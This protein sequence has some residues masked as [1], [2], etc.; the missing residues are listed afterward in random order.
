MAH[1]RVS[2]RRFGGPCPLD[3]LG[4]TMLDR[5]HGEIYFECDSCGDTLETPAREFQEA[6]VSLKVSKWKAR[7]VCGEWL[8]ECPDCQRPKPQ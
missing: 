5:I 6:L 1:H 2:R 7:K 3:P 8:H 4:L